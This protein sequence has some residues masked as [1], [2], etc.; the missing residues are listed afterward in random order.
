MSKKIISLVLCLCILIGCVCSASAASSLNIRTENGSV[1][2][3]ADNGTKIVWNAISGADKYYIKVVDETIGETLFATKISNTYRKL[4]GSDLAS[5]RRY[6]VLVKAIGNSKTLCSETFTFYTESGRGSCT[7]KSAS[8]S[9]STVTFSFS[10]DTNGGLNITDCGIV[11]GN[12]ASNLSN[13]IRYGSIGSQKGV[14]QVK[15]GFS[16]S[17]TIYYAAY[18]TNDAGTAYGS[19]KSVTIS[20]GSTQSNSTGTAAQTK[21]LSVPYYN[22]GDSRWASQYINPNAATKKTI[23]NIGCALTSVAMVYSYKKGTNTD[24]YTLSR[25][26]KFD[27]NSIY[28]TGFNSSGATGTIQQSTMKTLY[29]EIN[30]GNP[31]IVGA[32]PS[33]GKNGTWH[34][35]VVTGYENANPDNLKASNFLIN[36]PGNSSRKTLAD[37]FGYKPY[38]GQIVTVSNT[39]VWP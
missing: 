31:V 26:W 39:S 35:V 23:G 17:G 6:S 20:A 22:Q 37:L 12:S 7:T 14:F 25:K 15:A 21:K 38:C 8:T 11:W 30:K 33:S 24:P 19:A 29:N 9:G 16:G 28:W 1:W 3:N 36:D 18:C 10:V 13:R 2:V 32:Y 4:T 5:S 27:G 34:Y